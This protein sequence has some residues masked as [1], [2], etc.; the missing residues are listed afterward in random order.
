MPERAGGGVARIGVDDLS[1]RQLL[2]VQVREGIVCHEDFAAHL[3]HIGRAVDGMWDIRNGAQ[4]CG[5]V[6][7]HL[8]V[9]PRGALNQG[10]VL[11]AQGG[12]QP[13]D[14]W[15]R[16]DGDGLALGQFQEPPDTGQKIGDVR[17]LEGI[18]Q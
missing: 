16:H 2:A 5:D 13:V 11:I 18:A 12:G 14:L 15:L 3:E 1:S 8:A 9:A 6:L 10:A 7:A 4:I 17:F